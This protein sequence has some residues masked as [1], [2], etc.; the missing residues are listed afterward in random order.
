MPQS[1][2]QS[3]AMR[4]L[5]RAYA[6]LLYAYPREFR[7]EYGAAMQQIFRDGCRDAVRAQG[8]FGVLRFA[9]HTAADWV[10]TTVRESAIPRVAAGQARAVWSAGRRQ[11]PRGFVSEWVVTI[12]LYLFAATTLVQAYV[13]PTGSMEGTLRVGDHMLV[14]RVTYAEAGPVARHVLPYHDLERGDIV[15]FLYPEDIR[16]TYVKRVIGLPGDRIRLVNKQVIRNGRRLIEPYTQHIDPALDA[17]RDNFPDGPA[18]LTTP[19]GREM[20]LNHV[21]NGEVV[22]PPDAFFAMGDNRENSADS[23]YWGFVPR[24]YVVGKPL[25]IYW[26]FDAPTSDLEG[27]S[28]DHVLDVAVHFFSKTR[29]ER[30]LLVPRPERAQEI[31][32][33]P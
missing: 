27:W 22:V 14:D 5:C 21:V 18:Y 8:R 10:S 1:M 9:I 20:L 33:T 23:R 3:R 16:Q 32:D 11:A 7:L 12:L 15:A 24:R 17:Y 30:T 31:G 26:S 29:W 19:R 4:W 28:L 13:V 25:V 2:P 6:G